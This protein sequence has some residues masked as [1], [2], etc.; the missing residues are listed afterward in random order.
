MGLARVFDGKLDDL[1]YLFIR[2][3]DKNPAKDEAI[4]PGLPQLFGD[5]SCSIEPVALPQ[6]AWYPGVRASC[7]T[8]R[9]PRLAREWKKHSRI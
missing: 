7:A 8:T 6:S 4:K 1:T 2:G 9:S 3:N 5:A